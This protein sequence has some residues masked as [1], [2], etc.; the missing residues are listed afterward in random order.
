MTAMTESSADLL[1]MLNG[2]RRQQEVDPHL[3]EAQRLCDEARAILAAI[4]CAL[5]EALDGGDPLG[6]AVKRVQESGWL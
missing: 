1:D 3:D 6:A 5:E 2:M 4:R